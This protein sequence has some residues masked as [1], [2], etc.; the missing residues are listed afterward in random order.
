MARVARRVERRRR[1]VRG[2]I[3]QDMMVR[4]RVGFRARVVD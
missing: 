1:R 3:G 2:E 4:A